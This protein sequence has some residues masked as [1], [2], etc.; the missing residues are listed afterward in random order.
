MADVPVSEALLR[1]SA[2]PTFW[3]ALRPGGAPITR[4][5][6]ELRASFPVAGGYGLVLD[7]DLSTGEQ[8]VGLRGPAS[9]EP[10]QL[11]WAAADRPHPAALR[12]WE[13][14]LCARVIA[15][16][17]P[18]LPHPGLVVALLSPFAPA[19]PDDDAAEIAAVREAAYRS[20]RR[21]P[22]DLPE[23]PGDLP[24]DPGPE[25]APLPLFDDARWWPARPAPSA[26]VLD[27]AAIAAWTTP[28]TTST[29][30]RS[31]PRFPHDDLTRMLELAAE[32]LRSIGDQ[33]CYAGVRPLARR[34]A[35]SGDLTGV[36]D[37]VGALTEAGCDH[38]TVLDALSEPLVPE[39]AC[40]MVETLAGA[41]PGSLL[42][43]RV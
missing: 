2:D 40:W 22:G 41:A 5:S 1:R 36:P 32:R 24:E 25:Q 4:L 6:G 33:P 35:V 43:R 26:Q 37:L 17:D 18:T 19:T 21:D 42:R 39:E 7:V 28:A 3:A 11:G 12:W 10:V 34:I 15:L 23:D 20:L 38:P 13:L 16:D 27:E 14:D 29:E 9:S 31:G 30:V 8:S